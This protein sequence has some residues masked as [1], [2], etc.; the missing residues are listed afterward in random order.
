MKESIVSGLVLLGAVFYLLHEEQ[1]HKAAVQLREKK[2]QGTLC[3]N[4]YKDNL[5]TAGEYATI[6]VGWANAN[7][8]KNP[9]KQALIDMYWDNAYKFTKNRDNLKKVLP[10]VK[11]VIKKI[12]ADHDYDL[13]DDYMELLREHHGMRKISKILDKEPRYQW[14]W[15]K[16]EERRC[17][18]TKGEEKNV[19]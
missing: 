10:R 8:D 1:V 2:I 9:A 6:E 11:E 16:W 3:K 18:E 12:K 17:G 19:M 7:A 13:T 5:I 14:A 15:S 4:M